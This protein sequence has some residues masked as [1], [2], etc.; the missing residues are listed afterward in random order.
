MVVFPDQRPVIPGRLPDELLHRLPV[1][2]VQVGNRLRVLPLHI[3]EKPG[4][5]L[6]GVLPL[7]AARQAS[8]ERLDKS[9][10]AVQHAFRHSGIQY[11]VLQKLLQSQFKPPF[12][13]LLLSLKQ[14]PRKG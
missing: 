1:L 4:H 2:V 9:F 11:R 3:R 7:L 6:S 14:L 8:R 5:V 10:Q 12:H 13:W